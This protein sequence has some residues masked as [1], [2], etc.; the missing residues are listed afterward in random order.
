MALRWNPRGGESF[1]QTLPLPEQTGLRQRIGRQ[2]ASARA[3]W[4]GRRGDSR[5]SCRDLTGLGDG[6]WEAHESGRDFG[7]GQPVQD[8]SCR[9]LRDRRCRW[10]HASAR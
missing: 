1:L 5:R 6:L 3:R 7:G 8:S 4:R 2:G 10:A 9:I